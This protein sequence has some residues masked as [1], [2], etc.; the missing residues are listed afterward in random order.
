MID[1]S[2]Q[3]CDRHGSFRGIGLEI[4]TVL[5]SWGAK[6][7]IIATGEHPTSRP[8]CPRSTA[9]KSGV[10]AATRPTRNR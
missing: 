9:W 5:A 6:V 10:T 4:A 2:G 3:G 1:L 7:A 8:S